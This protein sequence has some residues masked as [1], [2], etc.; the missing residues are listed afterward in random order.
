MM[1]QSFSLIVT[2]DLTIFG[3]PKDTV[4]RFK[5]LSKSLLIPPPEIFF[6]HKKAATD[7]PK[8]FITPTQV[9]FSLHNLDY[10]VLGVFESLFKAYAVAIR[11][12]DTLYTPYE[13]RYQVL[14][15]YS[16]FGANPLNQ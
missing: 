15:S 4:S 13:F 1:T 3:N 6:D 14:F 12:I 7:D 8:V 10:Q 5:Y 11:D 16:P 9:R 2:F